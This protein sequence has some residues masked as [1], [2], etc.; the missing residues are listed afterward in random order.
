MDAADPR[1]QRIAI[2]EARVAELEALLA[3]AL[4]RNEELERANRELRAQLGQ[5]STNS[6]KPP[7]SDPPGTQ[8]EQKK[9]PSGRKPGGQPGHKKHERELAPVEQVNR[10]VELVPHACGTCGGRLRGRDPSPSR[11][12]LIDIPPLQA[13]ITEFRCHELECGDCGARTRARLPPEAKSLVGDRLGALICLMMGQY[14]LSK[15]MVQDLL[16]DLLGVELSLGM[17]PKVGTDMSQALTPAVAEAVAFVQRQDAVNADETGW[18][19]GKAEGRSRRAWLWVFAT[20][21][22][23]VFS[24]S[25]SRGS[26]VA[27]SMLGENFTGFLTTDRWSGYNWY[28][29]GLRQ[30]CWS[31]L[32]RD[33]QSLIERGGEPRRIGEALMRERH[34]MFKWWHRVRDGTMPREE[35]ERRMVKVERKVGRLLREAAVCSDAKV[36]GMAREILKLETAMWPFVQVPGLE[37]TNNFGERCIRHAVMWRKTSFGTQSPE[38]SRFVERILTVVTTLKLQRRNVL[39]YLTQTLA[40]HRRGYHGPS[41]L[42]SMLS[43]PLALAA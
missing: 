24:I 26:Q 16:S 38:G 12:Q 1:D 15:R 17:I 35:F 10:I 43:H 21:L 31:H 13:D 20:Q 28:D 42:P 40:A 11:H 25:R 6:S 27:R 23:V 33:I 2:L 8:R 36:A 18:F 7:S 22:V 3:A 9:P 41:L 37:P 14:R 5:N 30:L 32:T 19:E 29:V 39:E 4:K 34:R